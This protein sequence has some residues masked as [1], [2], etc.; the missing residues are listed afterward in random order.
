MKTLR[1]WMLGKLRRMAHQGYDE[2]SD[3]LHGHHDGCIKALHEV[4]QELEACEDIEQG[5]EDMEG[6]SIRE[7][8]LL[9]EDA[10]PIKAIYWESEAGAEHAVG[11]SGVTKILS[12][13]DHTTLWFAVYQGDFLSRRVPAYEVCVLYA[14]S[15]EKK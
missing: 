6:T 7:V 11:R 5:D 10:R 8:P 9:Y 14:D 15:G 13:L 4:L 3:Y 12:Y 2:F 1:E